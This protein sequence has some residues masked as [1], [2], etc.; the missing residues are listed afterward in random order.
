MCVCVCVFVE[1][2]ELLSSMYI[3]RYSCRYME[4]ILVISQVANLYAHYVTNG[5]FINSMTMQSGIL[6]Y[7]SVHLFIL[8]SSNH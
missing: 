2:L 5:S 8:R 3:T 1:G 6:L 4:M 7:F